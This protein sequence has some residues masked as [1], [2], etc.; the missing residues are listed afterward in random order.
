MLK[1]LIGLLVAIRV[2]K[3]HTNYLMLTLNVVKPPKAIPDV[4]QDWTIARIAEEAVP[5]TWEKV[6]EAAKNELKDTS[7]VLID[8]ERMY[9]EFYPL[10]RDI[11]T[12]FHKTPLDKVKVVFIGQDPYHQAVEFAGKSVPRAV[13]MSFSVRRGDSVPS[14]LKNMYTELSNTV[15][16]FVVPDHGDLSEWAAQGA[17]MLNMCLTVRPNTP[18]SHGDIWLGFL[19]RVFRA[20]AAINPYCIYVLWGQDAQKI[21]PM[22]GERS[23]ILEA[24]HP[25]GLSARRG[26]FGCNHFNLVNEHLLNQGKVAINWKLHTIADTAFQGYRAQEVPQRNLAPID[27]IMKGIPSFI[28]NVTQN[29]TAQIPQY[30]TQ[31]VVPI[32]MLPIIPNVKASPSKP[33]VT[34][35]QQTPPVAGVPNIP[36]INFGSMHIPVTL[37]IAQPSV[38]MIGRPVIAMPTH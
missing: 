38:E 30:N 3:L 33:A 19:N 35:P 8:Q 5:E 28:T 32:S 9:G 7:D 20:I 10:K 29:A 1:I 22:L 27:T 18:K 34:I 23:I 12:A 37:T 36:K 25:S 15:Q 21:K 6:F 13:G 17:L 11:F 14:S 31:K 4:Q 16:G 26:F 24:P 2:V